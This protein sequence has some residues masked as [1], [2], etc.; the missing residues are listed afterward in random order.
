[1][2]EL[3]EEASPATRALLA[4]RSEQYGDAWYLTGEVHNLLRRKQPGG[5]Q[6]LSDLGYLFPWMVTLSKLIR[7]MR[8]PADRDHWQDVIGYAQLVLDDLDCL[9]P[10]PVTH[11]P[12]PIVSPEE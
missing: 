7:A 3:K 9:V 4:Q 5:D 2:S 10:E 1:M 6:L 11:E 12:L 8:S